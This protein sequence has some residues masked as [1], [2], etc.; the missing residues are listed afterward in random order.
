MLEPARERVVALPVDRGD[1]VDRDLVGRDE[2]ADRL[3]DGEQTDRRGHRFGVSRTHAPHVSWPPKLDH[4]V[5]AR[6]PTH[7]HVT[8]LA[9]HARQH[10][11]AVLPGDEDERRAR[12][13]ADVVVEHGFTAG[14]GA[15]VAHDLGP[16]RDGDPRVD[17]GVAATRRG[18]QCGR[19]VAG[20]RHRDLGVELRAHVRELGGAGD[21]ERPGRSATVTAAAVVVVEHERSDRKGSA[22]HGDRDYD[23]HD[24]AARRRPRLGDH[25]GSLG[26]VV[27]GAGMSSGSNVLS[28]SLVASA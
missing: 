16:R 15:S 28:S 5:P 18:D 22:H 12:D 20:V 23:R 9:A 6:L 10:V 1:A 13:R 4:G 8:A 25:A 17:V 14:R 21:T 19:G 11:G 3:P 27:P 7:V 2:V 24:P 26:S